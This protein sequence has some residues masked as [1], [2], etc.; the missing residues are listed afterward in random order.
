MSMQ[1]IFSGLGRFTQ[2]L[3]FDGE[4]NLFDSNCICDDGH[5][6]RDPEHNFWVDASEGAPA[7]EDLVEED[8]EEYRAELRARLLGDSEDEEVI[9]RDARVVERPMDAAERAF[10]L[11]VL[12]TSDIESGTRYVSRGECIS[13]FRRFTS[14]PAQTKNE[15]RELA[16]EILSE[17]LAAGE[18]QFSPIHPGTLHLRPVA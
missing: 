10:L 12:S 9:A 7:P 14:E 15:K 5:D 11:D 4:G 16:R 8:M 13:S 18:R 17:E 6:P 3:D 1:T 2:E